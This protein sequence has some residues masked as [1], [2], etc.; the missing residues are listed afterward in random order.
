M[1]RFGGILEGYD[2]TE[3]DFAEKLC[4][5]TA[6]SS[7][8]VA[9]MRDIVSQAAYGTRAPEP[10]EED[11]V[12][13]MYTCFAKRVYATLSWHRKLIFRYWKAFY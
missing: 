6:V 9:R 10:H 3:E 4:R 12:L 8:D 2:G 11:Y 5:E 1:L 7:E 13:K